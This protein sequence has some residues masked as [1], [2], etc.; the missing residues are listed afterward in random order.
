MLR[1]AWVLAALAALVPL[2]TAAPGQEENAAAVFSETIDVRVV[3]IEVVVTDRDGNRVHGLQPSDFELLVDG[4]PTPIAYS[5]L[6]LLAHSTGGVP[7]INAHRNAALARVVA[8]T[9]SYYWLGF[10]PQRREDD[11]FQEIVRRNP[12]PARGTRPLDGNE[13]DLDRGNRSE[14]KADSWL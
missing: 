10:E 5:T 13:P 3:N 4:E 12:A 9:R 2:A 6:Q 11:A 14:L 8:D 7:L 1:V